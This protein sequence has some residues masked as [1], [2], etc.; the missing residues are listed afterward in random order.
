MLLGLNHAHFLWCLCVDCVDM[1][2]EKKI[3]SYFTILQGVLF[4]VVAICWMPFNKVLSL[5]DISLHEVQQC[6]F[7]VGLL[8]GGLLICVECY[9]HLKGIRT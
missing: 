5:L 1:K 6:L 2:K 8:I 4:F 3:Y 9:H 7:C